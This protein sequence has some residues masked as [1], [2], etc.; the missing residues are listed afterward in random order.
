VT[1]VTN[2]AGET[3]NFQ[4]EIASKQRIGGFNSEEGPN[5][6]DIVLLKDNKTLL[7]I[8][9]KDGGDGSPGELA[10]ST[11]RIAMLR[12][13]SSDARHLSPR[14]SSCPLPVRHIDGSW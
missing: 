8:I 10:T 11:T 4:G 1:Y 6:N 12:T 13:L 3:W 7:C 14:P 9:R 2:D 5:E